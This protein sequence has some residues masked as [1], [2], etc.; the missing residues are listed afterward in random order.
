MP[1]IFRDENDSCEIDFSAALWATDSLQFLQA[2]HCNI[3]KTKRYVYILECLNGD[4]ILR[5]RVRALLTARLPF[6]LQQQMHMSEK[7]IDSVEVLSV[8]EWN[9]YY[10]KY[11]LRLK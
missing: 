5:K 1:Q 8:M 11:P 4:V 9:T 6:L 3:S 2:I 10:P 7:M